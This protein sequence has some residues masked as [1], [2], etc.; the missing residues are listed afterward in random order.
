MNRGRRGRGSKVEGACADP[1]DFSRVR[2]HVGKDSYFEASDS[3]REVGGEVMIRQVI[4]THTKRATDTCENT[5]N[6]EDPKMH[7]SQPMFHEAMLQPSAVCCSAGKTA[8][9]P[10]RSKGG[11]RRMVSCQHF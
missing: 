3:D 9:Y 11:K 8:T 5:A 7:R 1:G 2:S 6:M 4:V 10:C